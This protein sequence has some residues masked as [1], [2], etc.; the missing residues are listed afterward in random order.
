MY[1]VYNASKLAKGPKQ[2]F[3]KHLFLSQQLQKYDN[4]YKN[5]I[6]TLNKY[7]KYRNFP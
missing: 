3:T 6:L 7:K 2:I 5:Q 4:Y 1:F